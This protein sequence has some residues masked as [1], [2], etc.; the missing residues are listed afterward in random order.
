[1]KKNINK[2]VNV[3][4]KTIPLFVLVL[5]G[6][7]LV[8][9]MLVGYISNTITGNVVVKSPMAV[10]FDDGSGNYDYESTAI[11]SF[12]TIHGGETFNYK[13]WCENQ[14]TIAINSYPIMTIISNN[15]WTGQEFTNVNFEDGGTWTGDILQM[16]YVIEDAGTLKKFTDG[17]W[18]VTDKTT[19]RLVFDNGQGT[20]PYEYL[21]GAESWNEI[22]TTTAL[23][24]APDTYTIKLCH[25]D[26]L[27]T[28]SCE[29]I[30]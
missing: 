14:G 9:A 13:S 21:A 2:K 25:I 18:G 8:S 16:L 20:L 1:M 24:I 30:V 11:K 22:T 3:F 10:A 4:G 27:E 12:G 15:E 28:G 6:V 7:G 26:N 17:G 23:T 5:L 19:L 29:I